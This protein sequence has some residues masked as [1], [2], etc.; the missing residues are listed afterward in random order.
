[1][2]C[3]ISKIS[4]TDT[5][6]DETDGMIYSDRCKFVN[7]KPVI[8]AKHLQYQVELFFKVIILDDPLLLLF[9]L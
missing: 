8:V 1:M 6:E 2:F 3:N 4:G 7:E 5:C 9:A